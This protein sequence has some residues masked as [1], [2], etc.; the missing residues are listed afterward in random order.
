MGKDQCKVLNFNVFIEGMKRHESTT[1]EDN[2]VPQKAK[3][4]AQF[5]PLM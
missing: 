5:K 1:I 2:V 4:V 3:S